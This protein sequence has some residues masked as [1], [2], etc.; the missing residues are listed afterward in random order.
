M[1]IYTGGKEYS[2]T[3]KFCD[4]LVDRNLTKSIAAS[5]FSEYFETA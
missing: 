2:E 5:C 4:S 1:S 3:L